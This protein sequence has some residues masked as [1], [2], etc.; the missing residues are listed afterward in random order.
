MLSVRFVSVNIGCKKQLQHLVTLNAC[1]NIHVVI[2]NVIRK[3]EINLKTGNWNLFSQNFDVIN[4]VLET[5]LI[6]S[7]MEHVEIKFN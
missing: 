2:N 5:F 7:V 3:N 6:F 4:K 1:S